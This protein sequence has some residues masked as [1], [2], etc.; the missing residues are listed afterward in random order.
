MPAHTTPNRKLHTDTEDSLYTVSELEHELR[1]AFSVGGIENGLDMAHDATEDWKNKD[2]PVLQ[3]IKGKYDHISEDMAEVLRPVVEANEEFYKNLESNLQSRLQR[4]DDRLRYNELFFETHM[5]VSD[6][7][8]LSELPESQNAI[9]VSD[10]DHMVAFDDYDIDLPTPLVVAHSARKSNSL[11][12]FIP[13]EN[14]LTCTC[15]DKQRRPDSPLCFH[16]LAALLQL[17]RNEFDPDGPDTWLQLVSPSA[18]S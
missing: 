2:I 7:T 4:A 1:I 10:L 9:H 15:G 3:Y 11:Y 16:E 13:H 17:N 12:P 14:V 5:V 8:D 18:D 6:D